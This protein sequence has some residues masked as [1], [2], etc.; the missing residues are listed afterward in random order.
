M[1]SSAALLERGRNPGIGYWAS[2]SRSNLNGQDVNDDRPESPRV[3]SPTQSVYS[4]IGSPKA[5]QSEEEVNLEYLRNIILQFLEH[6]EMRVSH[7]RL[8]RVFQSPYSVDRPSA[9]LGSR[10]VGHSTFYTRRNASV[11]LKGLELVCFFARELFDSLRST[12]GLLHYHCISISSICH[13]IND[14]VSTA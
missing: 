5:R 10:P 14:S 1:Q 11:S 2:K 7:T 12:F 13:T 8:R 9:G 4:D 6:R 3:L